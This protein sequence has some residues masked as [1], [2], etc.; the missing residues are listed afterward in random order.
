MKLQNTH[1]K[2]LS[3]GSFGC[4]VSPPFPKTN[5]RRNYDIVYNNQLLNDIGKIYKNQYKPA[6]I[7]Y[8]EELNLLKMIDRLDPH[9]IFTTKLKGA[10]AIDNI[11][12]TNNKIDNKIRECLNTNTNQD[13]YYQIILENG[14]KDLE[15]NYRIN[16]IYFLKKILTLIYGMIILQNNGLVHQDIKPLNVLINQKKFSLIDF[17]LMKMMSQI[18]T[19]DNLD[20]LTSYSYPYNPPEYLIASIFIDNK[21]NSINAFGKNEVINTL[22][23]TILKAHFLQ[24]KNIGKNLRAIYIEGI[25]DF[26]NEI[27]KNNKSFSEIFNKD[28]AMKADVFSF[29]YIIYEL[30]KHIIYKYEKEKI[31]VSKLY[32]Y[33]IKAN[34]YKRA[35]FKSL[36]NMVYHEIKR[37]SQFKGEKKS[38]RQ[39]KKKI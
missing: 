9:S 2:L 3:S 33:C 39:V 30:N 29:A 23:K 31:F 36:Y 7:V 15:N 20:R 38:V 25:T 32:H 1:N 37:I 8:R 22:N 12:I 18:Y 14:G 16:Y 5:N 4:V 11:S 35:T 13:T 34:P 19:Q 26:L 27:Y 24:N 21:V 28:L 10:F 6:D 17:G